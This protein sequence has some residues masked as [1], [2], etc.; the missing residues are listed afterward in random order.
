M[1]IS[2]GRRKS[3]IVSEAG[4]EWTDTLDSNL[5]DP[6]QA[7]DKD[8]EPINLTPSEPSEQAE[9]EQP[10]LFDSVTNEDN[11]CKT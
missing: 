6:D 11:Q 3:P 2:S 7:R 10:T 8:Q 9:H 5:L 4:L 1:S